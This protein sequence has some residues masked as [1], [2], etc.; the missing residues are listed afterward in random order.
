MWNLFQIL[1]HWSSCDIA[2]EGG[3]EGKGR[4]GKGREGKGEGKEGKEFKGGKG[5]GG[6][7]GWIEQSYYISMDYTIKDCL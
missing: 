2:D 4:E 5:M 7:G 3:M 1:L 6:R